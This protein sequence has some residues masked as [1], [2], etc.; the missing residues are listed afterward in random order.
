MAVLITF[1]VILQTVINL[2]MLSLGEWGVAMSRASCK[3]DEGKL[4]QPQ[5]RTFG[6]LTENLFVGKFSSKNAKFETENPIVGKF[7]S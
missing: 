1:P 6:R 4:H 3:A 2:R 7:K 5:F